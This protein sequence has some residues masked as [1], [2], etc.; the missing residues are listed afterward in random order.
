MKDRESRAKELFD[1]IR[2]SEDPPALL[3]G[4]VQTK[5]C[6]SD[7]LE[8]KG[9]GRIQDKQAKEYWSRVLSGFANTEGGVLIWGISTTQ[10]PMPDDPSRRIDAA[11]GLD[12]VPNPQSFMQMLK[13]VKLEATVHPVGGVEYASW[14]VRQDDASGF[15]VCLI[16]EG[17]NKPY[18]AALDPAKQYFQRIGD[19]FTHISHSMLASLFYPRA[20]PQLQLAIRPTE[21]RDIDTTSLPPDRKS[22]YVFESYLSNLGT[23]SGQ[24]VLVSVE[25]NYSAEWAEQECFMAADRV[26]G[27]A[28]RRKFLA[29]RPIHP[30]EH[31]VYCFRCKVEAPTHPH[32]Q[33]PTQRAVRDAQGITFDVGIYAHDAEPA[34]S[35]LAFAPDE[36]TSKTPKATELD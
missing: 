10:I 36:I 7:F 1:E 18:R 22:L 8:F 16:P 23:G 19:S 3:E 24:D 26:Q 5:K 32:F 9:A 35:V 13:D 17:A 20:V 2:G 34:R 28:R 30:D 14:D 4:F 31:D 27:K 21:C 11:S 12:L 29:N 6:E 25:T 15:V 33:N